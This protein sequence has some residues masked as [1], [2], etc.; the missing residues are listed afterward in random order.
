MTREARLDYF[1][2]KDEYSVGIFEIDSQHRTLIAILN[3][4]YSELWEDKA[5]ESLDAAIEELIEY[6]KT[7]FAFEEALME[8][9]GYPG[10]PAHQAIH[11][12][13]TREVGEFRNSIDQ[14]RLANPLDALPFLK[15]WLTL[16][17][18]KQDK[19]YAS[20]IADLIE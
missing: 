5:Q 18:L 12:K 7:H 4:L 1:P 2:W 3:R 14:G 17:I 10:L 9:Y 16:H 8:K 20:L 19:E 6:T 13:L 11:A 15:D